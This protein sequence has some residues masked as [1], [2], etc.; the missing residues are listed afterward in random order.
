MDNK[1]N[2]GNIYRN[3]DNTHSGK[4]HNNHNTFCGNKGNKVSDST[5]ESPV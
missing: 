4:G 2:K 5:F 1:N 3:K